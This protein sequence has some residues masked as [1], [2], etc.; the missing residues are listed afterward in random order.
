MGKQPLSDIR[1]LDVS[2][3]LAAPVTAT[4]LGDFGAEVI[5]VERPGSG[6]FTRRQATSQGGRS[7]QWVQEG[8]NKKSITLDLHTDVGQ[9]V[10]KRLIPLCDVMVTNYRPSTLLR[11][12]LAPEAVMAQNP[13][14]IALY[15]TGFGLTGPYRDRGA[16]DRV[17]SAFAGLTYVTGEADGPPDP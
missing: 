3:I 2:S 7:L 1:V 17:A 14:L 5:K 10:L 16:F 15:V 8:R 6:D 12:G 11:W 9:R 13:R 4:L